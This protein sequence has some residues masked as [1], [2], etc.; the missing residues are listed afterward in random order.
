MYFI[1]ATGKGVESE[2]VLVIY[3]H[4]INHPKIELLKRDLLIISHGSVDQIGTA[5]WF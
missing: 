1:V 5:R 4:I 3:H 2:D